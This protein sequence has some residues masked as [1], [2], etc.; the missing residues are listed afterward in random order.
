MTCNWPIKRTSCPAPEIDPDTG[1]EIEG[2]QPA[3][4]TVSEETQTE[5][6]RMAVDLLWNWTGRSFGKLDA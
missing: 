4:E 5:A 3:F 1:D 6:E 2:G